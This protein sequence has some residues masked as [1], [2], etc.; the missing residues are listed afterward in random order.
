MFFGSWWGAKWGDG[1][2]NGNWMVRLGL[3]FWIVFFAG[4]GDGWGVLGAGVCLL[5]RDIC[6]PALD[7]MKVPR[8]D[9]STMVLYS[10]GFRICLFPMLE[11]D[12]TN[13]HGMRFRHDSTYLDTKAKTA[14]MGNPRTFLA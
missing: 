13:F 5:R 8:L 3:C 4:V 14:R 7:Y 10:P 9:S 11:V 12:I 6:L 1:M 2:C